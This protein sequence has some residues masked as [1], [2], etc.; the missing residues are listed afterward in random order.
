[1]TV[2]K[3]T[4]TAVHNGGVKIR[5]RAHLAASIDSVYDALHTPAIFRAVSAPFT[6]F[7]TPSGEALPDRFEPGAD[8]EVSVSAL[9]VIPMGRQI[10]HLVDQ[11]DAWDQRSVTD[12]GRGLSGVLKTL[13]GWRHHMSVAA[14]ADGGTDFSDELS[15]D[16]SLWSVLAWP[17]LQIFW[18]WRGARLRRLADSFDSPVTKMWNE[19]YLGKSSMWSGR[20]NPILK[21]VASEHTPT[22][23]IDVG[24]GEGADALF[25]AEL[26]ADTL[27]VEASSVGV[28]RGLQEQRRR[29]AESGKSLPVHWAVAD[30]AKPWSWNSADADFVSLQF[31]H[32]DS[33]TRARIWAEAVS[34]VAPGGVLLIVGHDQSDS[35]KG[36]PRPPAGLCFDADELRSAIPQSWTSVSVEKRERRQTINDTTHDVADIVLVAIR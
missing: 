20:V 3:H 33:D 11:A 28:Y 10:I 4:D 27:A 26:G 31:I 12:T 36:I 17:G 24:A 15:I 7:R 22:R 8:Y 21:Q 1:M 25:L 6:V 2:G 5:T 18:W 30:I 16:F 34:A 13:T 29:E 35:E 19:R 9:G 14:R 32:T 23:A